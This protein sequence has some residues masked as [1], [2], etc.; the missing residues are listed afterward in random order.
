MTETVAMWRP[1]VTFAITIPKDIW[2]H[3][4]D[5]REVKR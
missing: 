1:L 2:G 5:W 3:N 4:A